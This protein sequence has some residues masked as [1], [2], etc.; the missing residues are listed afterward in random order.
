VVW[1]SDKDYPGT[2]NLGT[3]LDT[4][5]RTLD[6][7]GFIQFPHDEKQYEVEQL[8]H[9][10][11]MLLVVDNAETI[12]DSTLLVWLMR[13]PEPSKAIV[14]TREYRREFRR[15]GWLV[16][17]RG[18]TGT[19]MREL[20]QERLRVLKIDDLV[21]A[22]EQ[23]DPLMA[24]TGGNPKAIT[25]ALGL[26]KYERRSLQQVVD[27]LYMVR[28]D[29]FH[30]LFT[31]TWALLDET[32]RQV[33]LTMP[34]FATSAGEDAIAA[35]ADIHGFSFD[36]AVNALSDLSLLD[37]RQPDVM[38]RPRYVLHPL[39]RAFAQGKLLERPRLEAELRERWVAWYID[40][41]SQI[42]YC[43]DDLNRLDVLDPELDT[44]EAVIT[45][46]RQNNHHTE[47]LKMFRGV[48]YYYCVRG[49]WDR[50]P[51]I[52]LIGAN[53]AQNL[54][55]LV[56]EA[57][58]IA[59]HIQVLSKQGGV[60]KVEP[61]MHR[62]EEI[63]QQA[64]LSTAAFFELQ[65]AIALYALARQDTQSALHIWQQTLELSAGLDVRAYIT[66]RRWL[67][68]CLYYQG[69]TSEAQHLL[70]ETLQEAVRHTYARG[71]VSIQIRL[72]NIYLDQH[73]L[74]K[75]AIALDS[76][77]THVLQYEERRHTAEL[78]RAFARLHACRG[79]VPAACDALTEAIDLFKRIGMRRELAE[80]REE[81]ARIEAHL[82]AVVT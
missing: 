6:Y 81:L 54:T 14:T 53:G 45:W 22:Y 52:T 5:A 2:T 13:L 19:E 36:R 79:D 38:T 46:T 1:I 78:R 65:H 27:E 8:L 40:L 7:P 49:L 44:I 71:I 20:V 12:T 17:L 70:E 29:L 42:G 82:A 23:L 9:R 67:A 59:Y 56:E 39:V 21:S 41:V 16:E 63:I 61:F 33:L 4:I 11:R 50:N 28:G 58:A 69:L 51:P 26:L 60:A 3:V 68:T 31:R 47:T 77:Q 74:D 18:M 80:A 24:T 43:W 72:A 55:D 48:G 32:A 34:L 73:D 66:N 64:Q 37:V 30:D 10:Q 57:E 62:L 75:A 15:G 76:A 25:M 35:V